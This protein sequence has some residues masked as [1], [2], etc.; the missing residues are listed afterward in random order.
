MQASK[1]DGEFEQ[2]AELSP[3]QLALLMLRLREKAHN[4][5]AP[6]PRTLDIQPAPRDGH[7]PLSFAQQR[8]WFLAQLEPD[9][10]AYTIPII[11]RMTEPLDIAAFR[12]SLNDI[13]RRHEVLRTTFA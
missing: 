11:V 9:T 1:P 6:Q 12:Q 8:L 5:A 4:R 13:A 10:P 3:E 7:L 2:V